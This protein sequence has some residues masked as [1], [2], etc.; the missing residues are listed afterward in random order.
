MGRRKNPKDRRRIDIGISKKE[1][2][3]AGGLDTSMKRSMR[4]RANDENDHP[5]AKEVTTALHFSIEVCKVDCI[6]YCIIP[7]SV[8]LKDLLSS[9]I[10]CPKFSIPLLYQ[11]T[12]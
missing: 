9:N 8:G 7:N 12:L 5:E 2:R 4:Q 11:Q 3:T 10:Y 6:S 1:Y